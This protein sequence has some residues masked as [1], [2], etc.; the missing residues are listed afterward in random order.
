MLDLAQMEDQEARQWERVRD[1]LDAALA[2]TPDLRP[3]YLADACGS[4]AGLR[5]EINR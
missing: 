3:G 2:L 1:I 4:D 5:A